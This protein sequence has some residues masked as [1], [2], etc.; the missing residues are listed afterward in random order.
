MIKNNFPGKFIVLEGLD[1]AGKSTQVP[2]ILEYFKNNGGLAHP[3][4]EPTQFLTGGLIRSRL[5]GEWQCSPECLQLLFA[6]DRADHIE[7]EI[8]PK[9]KAGVNVVSDRYF[10]S[11]VVYGAIDSDFDWLAQINSRF[12]VP[13]LTIYLDVPVG[14]CVKRLADNGRSIELFEK[15]E[16]LEKVG[17]NYKMA[18]GRFENDCRISIIDGNKN[19]EDVFG[20]IKKLLADLQ[21]SNHCQCNG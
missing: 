4:S 5:M 9:L 14:V 19:M 16:V 12:L 21:C 1:G 8:A 2:L 15:G 17:K 11:S 6:A 20:D 7:K 18:I 3:T 10:M 13:D